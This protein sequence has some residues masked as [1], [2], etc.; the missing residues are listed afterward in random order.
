MNP[1]IIETVRAIVPVVK[2]LAIRIGKSVC[3]GIL[4]ELAFKYSRRI[5][6]AQILSQRDRDIQEAIEFHE[7]FLKNKKDFMTAVDKS[8]AAMRKI[9]EIAEK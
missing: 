9:G 6:S 3:A 8:D 5:C 2:P 4:T 7:A 1:E